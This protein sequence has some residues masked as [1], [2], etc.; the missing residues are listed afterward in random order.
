[1][2]VTRPGEFQHISGRL[3]TSQ[4]F[5][6]SL[7]EWINVLLIYSLL[8]QTSL[9]L[10]LLRLVVSLKCYTKVCN[11]SCTVCAIG[12]LI[13]KVKSKSDTWREVYNDSKDPSCVALLFANSIASSGLLLLAV[14]LYSVWFAKMCMFILECKYLKC[15]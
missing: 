8:M 4:A 15:T 12:I 2:I 6:Y 13:V 7:S 9:L 1:M 14:E 11:L 5:L 3:R 10:L